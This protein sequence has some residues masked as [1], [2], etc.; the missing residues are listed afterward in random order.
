MN[1][2]LA[3]QL[4][5]A[6][7]PQDGI[8]QFVDTKLASPTLSELIEACGDD[9]DGLMPQRRVKNSLGKFVAMKDRYESLSDCFFGE[10]P[11]EAVAKLWLKLNK[12]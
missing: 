11:E 6:G 8:G 12:K 10:T 2:E 5:E 4:K 9:F 7:F 3:R 1:Y